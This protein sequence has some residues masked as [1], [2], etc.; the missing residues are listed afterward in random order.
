MRKTRVHFGKDTLE[1]AR[2]KA[3]LT[4][5]QIQDALDISS[6]TWSR[7]KKDGDV[8][9]GYVTDLVLLLGLPKPP[10]LPPGVPTAGWETLERLDEVLGRVQ[11]I[12]DHLGLSRDG[13]QSG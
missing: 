4:P 1:R 8:P 3:D 2:Q 10:D 5:K 11:G 13:S 6:S 12:E 7:W 9:L